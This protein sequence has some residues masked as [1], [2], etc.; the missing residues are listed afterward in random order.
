MKEKENNSHS[1]IKWVIESF[2]LTFV[3]S[4]LISYISSNG[5]S[6]LNIFWA[7]IILVLVIF[8]GI[9]FDIVGVAVTVANEADFHAKATKKVRGATTSLK[10]IKNASKVAN[11]CADVIGDI[12]GVVSGAI[13]TMIAMKII[14][15]YGLSNNIQFIISALVASLTVSGK[16]LGKDIAKKEST[17]I[18]HITGIILNKFCK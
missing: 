12:C 17:P 5:V 8:I 18:V 13:S 11:I 7:I 2:I 6:S 16:A 1:H 9:F 14:S 4:G 10:L 3:L 15:N